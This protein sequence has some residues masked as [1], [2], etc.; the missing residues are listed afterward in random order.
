[1]SP[2]EPALALLE[3]DSVAVGMLSADAVVKNAPVET[4]VAGTVHP[5]K[6]LVLIAGEIAEVEIGFAAGSETGKDHLIDSLFLPGVHSGVTDCL[7]GRPGGVSAEAVGVVE[8]RSVASILAAAD[9]GLKGAEVE[10]FE[11]R[12]ADGLGGKAFCC[13]SGVLSDV[14]AA[15]DLA[16]SSLAVPELL[17][18]RVVIPQLHGEMRNNL[19]GKS[20]FLTRLGGS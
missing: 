11:L 20:A 18:A 14:E 13:F 6:Y 16:C 19:G 1:M 12:L 10:L 8:T 7:S 15:V 9:A 2:F 3:F 5:G 17:I 4:L